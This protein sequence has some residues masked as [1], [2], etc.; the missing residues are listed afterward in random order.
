MINRVPLSAA[1]YVFSHTR[2]MLQALWEVG[3]HTTLNDRT[4]NDLHA[5]TTLK[6]LHENGE[7]YTVKPK[8]KTTC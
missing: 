5:V 8:D 3:Y 7:E 1:K 2:G 4:A 6:I